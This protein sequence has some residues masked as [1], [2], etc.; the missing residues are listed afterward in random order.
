VGR[1]GRG[2]RERGK[3]GLFV[4]CVEITGHGN[5]WTGLLHLGHVDVYFLLGVSNDCGSCI[6]M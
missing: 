4:Y 6:K 5:Y 2:G 1:G 3:E